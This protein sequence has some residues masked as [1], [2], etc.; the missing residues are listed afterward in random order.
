M[1]T[2]ALIAL[3]LLPFIFVVGCKTVHDTVAPVTRPAGG[4]VAAPQAVT[5]GVAEGYADEA[6]TT[7]N[8][9]YNR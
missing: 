7:V 3:V 8:N 6:G 9:P 1:K 2:Q 5:Q 4:V